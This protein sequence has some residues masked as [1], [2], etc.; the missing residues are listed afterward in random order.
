MKTGQKSSNSI[1]IA[2]ARIILFGLAL[3][4]AY[5]IL[6]PLLMVL[7]SV[8][9]WLIKVVVFLAVAVLV[10]HLFLKIIFGIDL[11]AG[12]TRSG[13]RRKKG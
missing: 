8:S 2:A 12:Y 7:L 10:I 13:S 1:L 4:L 9:F 6:K 3:Y 11:L 5:I